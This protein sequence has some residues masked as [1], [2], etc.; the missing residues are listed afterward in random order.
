MVCLMG[1]LFLIFMLYNTNNVA[2]LLQGKSPPDNLILTLLLVS[3][4]LIIGLAG[5]QANYIHYGLDQLFKAPNHHL[6][7]FIHFAS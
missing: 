1:I 2:E 4:L 5:Y 6:A 3:L 7:L